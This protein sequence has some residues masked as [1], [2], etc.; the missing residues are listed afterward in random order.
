MT[1]SVRVGAGSQDG[2]AGRDETRNGAVR[3]RAATTTER[4]AGS[5]R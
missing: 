1:P 4:D 5:E 2:L 3:C